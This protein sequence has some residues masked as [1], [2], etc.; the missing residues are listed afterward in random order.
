[1]LFA[2][3]AFFVSGIERVKMISIFSKYLLLALIYRAFVE[4]YNHLR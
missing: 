2:N 4:E 1:M 3:S